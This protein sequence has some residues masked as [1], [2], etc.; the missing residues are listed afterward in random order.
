MRSSIGGC[1]IDGLEGGTHLVRHGFHAGP[2]E[3]EAHLLATCRY[4]D[5]NAVEARPQETLDRWPWSG[6]RAAVGL[7]HP[8][9]FHHVSTLLELF[10]PTPNAARRSYRRF[11]E[12]GLDPGRRVSTPGDGDTM[13]A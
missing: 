10:G 6:Y 11:V 3:N 12:A 5:L 9:P 1:R 2:L 4:I 7:D 13:R 8:R